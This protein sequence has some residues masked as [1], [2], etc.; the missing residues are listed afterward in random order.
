MNPIR[1]I[2]NAVNRRTID[3]KPAGG[4]T[5]EHRVSLETALRAYTHTAALA[6]FE[7]ASKGRLAPGYLADLVVLSQDL[8]KI[9]PMKIHETRVV[10]TVF[11]GRVIYRP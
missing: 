1:G 10:T 2:H 5:P 6:S 3:G 4:W 9:D 7:E 8:F 11:D